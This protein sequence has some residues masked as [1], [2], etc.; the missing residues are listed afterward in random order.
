MTAIEYMEKQCQKHLDDYVR[1]VNRGAPKQRT[2]NILLK[3]RYYAEAVDAL[4]CV[5]KLKEE[6]ANVKL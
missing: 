6:I 4:Q 1:E 5:N 2:D 3:V